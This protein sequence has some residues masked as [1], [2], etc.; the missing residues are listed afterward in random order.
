MSSRREGRLGIGGGFELRSF[1]CSNARPQGRYRWSKECKFPIPPLH[2]KV[3]A[4]VKQ[5]LK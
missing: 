4:L 3:K 2:K 5:E 1:F